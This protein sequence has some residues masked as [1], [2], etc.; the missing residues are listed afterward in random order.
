ML[1]IQNKI[2][3]LFPT[4]RAQWERTKNAKDYHDFEWLT[5]RSFHGDMCACEE[6]ETCRDWNENKYAW[7]AVLLWGKP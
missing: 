2:I 4:L 3:S 5:K 7:F 1:T 6:C